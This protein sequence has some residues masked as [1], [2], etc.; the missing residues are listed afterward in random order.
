MSIRGRGRH[1]VIIQPRKTERIDGRR[2]FVVDGPPVLIRQCSVQSVREW[3]T[4]EEVLT[5]GL[6]LISMRRVFARKWAGD[7][8]A[9]V[10]FDGGE[11]EVIGDPQNMDGSP[12]TKHWLTTIRWLGDKPAPVIP[13]P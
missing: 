3:A 6:Q 8:N 9:L 11:F 1:S 2:I 7:V 12:R 10:Y 13:D 4:A 5:Y